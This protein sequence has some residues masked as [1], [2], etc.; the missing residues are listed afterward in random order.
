MNKQFLPGRLGNPDETF[1]DDPRADPGPWRK[2]VGE[3]R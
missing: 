2:E 1:L 3:N